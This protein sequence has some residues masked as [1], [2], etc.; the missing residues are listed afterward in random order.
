MP[1]GGRRCNTVT[2][3]D[4]KRRKLSES[5]EKGN[6]RDVEA[7]YNIKYHHILSILNK[8]TT[9]FHVKHSFFE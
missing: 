3:H 2:T 6:R 9:M 7:I 4:R 8:Q 1:R 5:K